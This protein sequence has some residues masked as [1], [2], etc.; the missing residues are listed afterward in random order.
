MFVERGP[1][2]F[3]RVPVVVGTERRGS[4]AVMSGLEGKQR[5]VTEGVLLL[6]QVMKSGGSK[7]EE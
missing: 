5:I 7:S 3:E 1:G 4:L 6:L 2:K